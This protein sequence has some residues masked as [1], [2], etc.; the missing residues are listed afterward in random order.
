MAR[1]DK[2]VETPTREALVALVEEINAVLQPKTPITVGRKMTDEALIAVIKKEA[3]GNIYEIDFQ[4]DPDD[5]SVEIFSEEGEATIKLLGIEILPGAPP[6]QG[7][8]SGEEAT[9]PESEKT[10]PAETGKGKGNKK[11]ETAPANSETQKPKK[12]REP[13]YT[14]PNAFVDVLGN[15]GKLDDLAAKADALYVKNGGTSNPTMAKWYV[16]EYSRLFTLMGIGEV[17]DGSLIMKLK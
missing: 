13:K 15:G 5:A 3:E 10:S 2:K 11:N 16:T 1:G 14:R 7:D 17:K 12:E 9:E 4:P 8:D 6:V